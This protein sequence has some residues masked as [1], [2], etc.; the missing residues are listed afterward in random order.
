M[1]GVCY[2]KADRRRGTKGG[3][4]ISKDTFK[5]F[6]GFQKCFRG[7]NRKVFIYPYLIA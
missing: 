3:V 5:E 7:K 6:V 2:D 4:I 1:Q